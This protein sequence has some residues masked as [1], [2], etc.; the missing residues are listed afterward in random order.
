[1]LL[2]VLIVVV[3][4][5]CR[6]SVDSFR[7]VCFVVSIGCIALVRVVCCCCMVEL[8][9]FACLWLCLV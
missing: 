7:A 8:F 3:S 6:L 4:L 2:L 1:M 5:G 9:C